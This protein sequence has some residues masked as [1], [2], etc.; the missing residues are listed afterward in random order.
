M[1]E[2]RFDRRNRPDWVRLE[3]Y[4]ERLDR[5]RGGLEGRDVFAFVALY[6][7][8]TGDLARARM[9]KLS[10]A[11]VDYLNGLVG[12]VH[13][14]MY[15]ARAV[16]FRRAADFY[17]SDF[18][19]AA[20][21]LWRYVAVSAALLFG[22]AIL[23][24]VAVTAAPLLG[25]AFAPP[26]YVDQIEASFG[27]S[28]GRE[29]RPADLNA[30]MGS[31]Y[32]VNNIQVSFFCFALGF[33]LGLGSALVLAYNGAIL[34][35]V[36]AIIAQHGL[37]YNFWSFVAPHGGIELGAI[38]LSGAA[39]LRIGVA[40]VNPGLRSRAAALVDGARE[41]GLLMFGVISLLVLAALIEAFISP[42][43]LPNAVKIALGALNV[44]GLLAYLIL[45]G[46]RT[47]PLP[48]HDPGSA[49]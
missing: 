42:S 29:A 34:G 39:G 38:V 20:R 8:V 41:A 25:P 33:F 18:P 13:F 10:P 22:P 47:E 23:A 46:R 26:G 15:A 21:R 17:R 28:F 48:V 1:N 14:R 6:R 4:A 5:P 49:G 12:K 2:P 3:A 16:P 40:L 31:F 9:L 27:P 36:G 30:L 19:R 35:G 44:S 7:K 11:L 24:A 37:A 32:I 45:A 43:V